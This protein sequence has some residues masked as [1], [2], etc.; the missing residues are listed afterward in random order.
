MEWRCILCLMFSTR[1]Y[2][3]FTCALFLIWLWIAE[4]SIFYFSFQTLD[5]L[6]PFDA[7]IPL[8]DSL[9]L[10]LIRRVVLRIIWLE[11][12][13]VYFNGTKPTSVKT[14][15]TK[16]L[17][18]TS[19]WCQS[20]RENYYFKLSLIWPS[21][22]KDLPDLLLAKEDETVSLLIIL[23]EMEEGIPED[24]AATQV[25][26]GAEGPS[27]AMSGK[28]KDEDDSIDWSYVD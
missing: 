20:H 19:F 4:F 8:K 13:K 2:R 26:V 18:L 27:D 16:I 15:G 21:D 17:F 22:I 1:E 24:V 23:P 12:N 3:S 9:L 7:V 6:W 14:I 5:E 25:H 11:I 28:Y 10:E